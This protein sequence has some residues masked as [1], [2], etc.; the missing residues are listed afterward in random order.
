MERQFVSVSGYICAVEK[1]D[2]K[3]LRASFKA[4]RF[5]KEYKDVR[6]GDYLN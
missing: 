4:E 3:A 5:R 2:W 6:E 1:C